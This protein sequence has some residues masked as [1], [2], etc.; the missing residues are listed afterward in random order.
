V[1]SAAALLLGLRVR[2]PLGGM[3]VCVVCCAVKSKTQATAIKSK[4][5]VRKKYK[6]RTREGLQMRKNPDEGI[7]VCL[8]SLL[9]AV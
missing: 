7:D 8:F 5:R 3:N 2:I 4:K 6:E 9:C 1:K